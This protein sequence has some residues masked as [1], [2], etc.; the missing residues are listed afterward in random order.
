M[1]QT[2]SERAII[3]TYF[4]AHRDTTCA[5]QYTDGARIINTINGHNIVIW[6]SVRFLIKETMLRNQ[7][8]IS[9]LFELHFKHYLGTKDNIQCIHS[10][11]SLS[12][13]QLRLLEEFVQIPTAIWFISISCICTNETFQWRLFPSLNNISRFHSLNAFLHSNQMVF[14]Q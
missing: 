8:P 12:S 4:F 11:L 10:H 3:I 13:L 9:I 7:T 1:A 6:V 2:K 5:T 14:T